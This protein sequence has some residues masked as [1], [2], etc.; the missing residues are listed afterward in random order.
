MKFWLCA[1]NDEQQGEV[2]EINDISQVLAFLDDPRQWTDFVVWGS[3]KVRQ[4]Y[5]GEVIIGKVGDDVFRKEHN[6]PDD[7][8]HYIEIYNGYRE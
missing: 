6:I 3:D 4:E 7:V 2:I 8:T 1:T 5:H